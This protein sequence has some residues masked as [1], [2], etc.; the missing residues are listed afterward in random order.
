MAAEIRRVR[1][2]RVPVAGPVR[3]PR[4]RGEDGPRREFTEVL[5]LPAPA[6]ERAEAEPDRTPLRPTPGS[7]EPGSRLDVTA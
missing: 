1:A 2:D 7:D 4:R 6:P 5:E 3:P